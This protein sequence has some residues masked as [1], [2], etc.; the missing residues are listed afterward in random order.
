MPGP[1]LA[2]FG[3]SSRRWSGNEAARPRAG[4][5]KLE[6]LGATGGTATRLSS[7]ATASRPA[8]VRLRRP[9]TAARNSW[10]SHA[11]Q[12]S[13]AG[14]P[15]APVSRPTTTIQTASALVRTWTRR[16]PGIKLHADRLIRL[17]DSLLYTGVDV[18]EDVLLDEQPAIS[19]RRSAPRWRRACSA[20]MAFRPSEP[21]VWSRG[22]GDGRAVPA[23]STTAKPGPIPFG[24]PFLRGSTPRCSLPSPR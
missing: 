3:A 13:L 9:S 17:H 23:V 18:G 6:G 14:S 20:I 1:T 22:V 24:V 21:T 19:A 10:A 11:V 15:D 12:S 4:R 16:V 5:P 8:D 2:R 7:H